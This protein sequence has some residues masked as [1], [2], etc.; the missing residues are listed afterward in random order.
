MAKTDESNRTVVLPPQVAGMITLPVK[1]H[2]EQVS[3]R[4][5]RAVRSC[6][7][8]RRFRFHDLRHYY[9]S[10]AH[11]LG[12]PDAYVMQM[13]GWKTD[14]VMHRVYRDTLVDV[15]ADEQQKLT[16]HF[17]RSFCI[18]PQ[19]RTPDSEP[20]N[21]QTQKTRIVTGFFPSNNYTDFSQIVPA[22]GL[23]P[24][25][26]LGQQ[27]LSLPRLPF[28]HAGIQYLPAGYCICRQI[29]IHF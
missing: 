6:G 4:F 1:L 15:M 20:T 21:A 29:I 7:C 3:N 28:R 25:R 17:S 9:V 8:E 24:T 12:V 11:A 22:V 27:I 13:G 10:I 16:N 23:E 14:H 19:N 18:D 2:P 5:R 26:P